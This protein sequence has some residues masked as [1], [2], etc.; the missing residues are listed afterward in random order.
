[1]AGDGA[2]RMEGKGGGAGQLLPIGSP[3]DAPKPIKAARSDILSALRTI[4][5]CLLLGDTDYT[6]DYKKMAATV[7]P[8]GLAVGKWRGILVETAELLK[9]NSYFVAKLYE[10]D[11]EKQDHEESL[12]L[13]NKL[14]EMIEEVEDVD[15]KTAAI[16]P[17][18]DLVAV[19]RYGLSTRRG[20][21]SVGTD[22]GLQ[23]PLLSRKSSR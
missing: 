17:E 10:I 9:V 3:R 16:K 14:S 19:P 23:P 22:Q 13:A 6:G 1:M 2:S 7:A 21:S 11:K 15:A 4:K 12:R 8:K 18:V 20:A 5:P